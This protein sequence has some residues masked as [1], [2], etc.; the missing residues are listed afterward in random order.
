VNTTARS[1]IVVGA[2]IGGLSAAVALRRAGIDVTLCERAPELR[3]AGFGLSVQSNAMNALRTLGMGLDDELLRVGGRVTMFSFREPGGALVRQLEMAAT[4]Q[5]LGAPAV[6]LARRDFHG[7]LLD[8]AGSDLRV[9]VGAEAVRFESCDDGVLLQLADGRQLWAD[10]LIGADGIN[11]TVRAQLHG[12]RTPRSGGFVCWLALTPFRHPAFAEGESVHFWGRGMRFGVHD[13]GHDNTYWWGTM[14]THPD[15]AA[16]WPH[17]K[18]DLLRRF[19]TWAPEIGEIISATPESDILALPAQDRPPL[20]W[21]GRGR[22]TLLGDAAHPM[23]PSLGQGANSAVEDSVVLGHAL[24]RHSDPAAALRE[25]E[26]R[27]LPRTTALVD[28]SRS[29]CRFEQT[30]NRA[31]ATARNRFIR[32]ASERQLLAAMAKPMTWPGFGDE[33]R[34][35]PLPR[36]LSALERWHWTADQVA[37]LHIAARVRISGEVDIYAIR[38]ALNALA[39]RHPLLRS[40][41]H[42]DRGRFGGTNPRFVPARLR[43]IPL[44]LV[45]EGSWLTEIDRELRDR[46]EPDAP[47]LR[48][49]LITVEP[50]AH[51]FVLTSTYAIADGVTVVSLARLVLELAASG[52]PDWAP[53]VSTPSGSENLVPDAFQGLRGKARGLARLAEGAIRDARTSPRRL[54]PDAQVPPTERLTRLAHR[55]ISGA[56]YHALLAECRHRRIL[57]QA[58]IGAALTTA[59]AAD[60]AAV[61]ANFTIGVSVPFRDH[62]AEPLDADTIGSFQAILPIPATCRPEESLWQS[63]ASFDT[64]LRNGIRR[65]HHLA[66]LGTL[67]ALTPRSPANADGVVKLLDTRGPGNMCMTHLDVT[68][69]PTRVGDWTLSGVQFVSGMSISGYL[70]LTAATGDD[71]LTLNLGYIDGVI[72]CNRAEALIENTTAALRKA[73]AGAIVTLKES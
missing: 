13:I 31:V 5:S 17:G 3:A 37:P 52:V 68:E 62:L 46:F 11:S 42:N 15:L 26:Q 69:F 47:L 44:R 45:D 7:L 38:A 33:Q 39:Q 22:V 14:S 50:D 35:G 72:S 53:E 23:L 6:V 8:A 36:R 65:R 51:D 10:V 59:A 60:V 18:A 64:Q 25:Y 66:A 57:P 43:P 63:A 71:E 54:S 12:A 58:A 40:A 2:G 67:G 30:T 49:T 48:A 70:M 21:W 20:S 41:I 61:Q 1:A 34:F 24:A 9:E 29:L 16:N 32:H 56:E 4:D 73:A 27:R 28:G 19:R 55:T